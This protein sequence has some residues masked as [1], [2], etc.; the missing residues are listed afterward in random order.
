MFTIPLAFGA[1]I[2]KHNYGVELAGKN[3]ESNMYG[4][5]FG[6][7]RQHFDYHTLHHHSVGETLSNIDY[8]VVLRDK[9]LS[10]YTGLIRIEQDARTCEAYQEN[11]NLLLSKGAKAETIPELEILNEDVR[12]SHGATIGPIDPL[13]VFYLQSRGLPAEL[14]TR[15][16]VAGYAEATMKRL[17]DDL[18]PRIRES[19]MRRLETI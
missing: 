7:A 19:V 17:P 9:A 2:A 15:M 12:C 16:I 11:R 13:E 14:A 3:A 18:K 1:T 6:S 4:L 10:A 8:K 5:A